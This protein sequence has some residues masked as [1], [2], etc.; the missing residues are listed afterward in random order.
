MPAI[1]EAALEVP[2]P[3]PRARPPCCSWA[4]PGPTTTRSSSR[5]WHEDRGG[6]GYEFAHRDD[7]EGRQ[8]LARASRWTRTAATSRNCTWNRTRSDSRSAATEAEI[9]ALKPTVEELRGLRGHD[10]GNG[11]RPLV[12]DDINHRETEKL[13]ETFKPDVFCAGIKEKYVV[14]KIGVPCKQ[15]HSY[16]YGGPYAGFLGAVNFYKE[17]DRMVNNKVW[18]R[19]T[20]PWKAKTGPQLT[21]V[22]A[23]RNVEPDQGGRHAAQTHHRRSEGKGRA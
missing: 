9:E 19:L 14:Q 4:A 23:C 15:L 21:A 5:N 1:V 2:S 13:I 18:K 16:D 20:P 17:I 7:Y 11:G 8:G 10:A 3:A 6:G 12:I 22:F